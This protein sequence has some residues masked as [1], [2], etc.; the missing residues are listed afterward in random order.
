LE[1]PLEGAGE[2]GVDRQA[3]QGEEEEGVELHHQMVVLVG[4]QMGVEEK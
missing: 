1:Q 3:P 4:C 2:E